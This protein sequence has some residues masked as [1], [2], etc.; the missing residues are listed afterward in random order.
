MQTLQAKDAILIDTTTLTQAEQVARIVALA[1]AAIDR[2][3][4]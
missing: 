2:A 4:A 1:E 3:S